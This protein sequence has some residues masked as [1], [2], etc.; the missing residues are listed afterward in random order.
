MGYVVILVEGNEGFL[1]YSLVSH[2]MYS[3]IV[4][5][6]KNVNYFVG[7]DIENVMPEFRMLINVLQFLIDL[8]VYCRLIILFLGI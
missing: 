7:K 5:C 6:Q 2:E 1:L 8:V 4:L 3:F